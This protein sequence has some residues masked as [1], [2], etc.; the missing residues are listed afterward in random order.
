MNIKINMASKNNNSL[1]TKILNIIAEVPFGKVV[2]YGQIASEASIRDSRIVGYALA[3]LKHTNHTVPWHRVVNRFGKI[4]FKKNDS[5]QHQANLLKEEG[6][7]FET[8]GSIDLERFGW[9]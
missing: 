4:S 2:T 7:R 1:H 9:K 8:D 3:N 6:I 5:I